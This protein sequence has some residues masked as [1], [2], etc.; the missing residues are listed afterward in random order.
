MLVLAKLITYS[1][2]FIILTRLG[3]ESEEKND[4]V[5][6]HCFFHCVKLYDIHFLGILFCEFEPQVN[7]I[8]I[9]EKTLATDMFAHSHSH[10]LFLETPKANGNMTVGYKLHVLV[11]DFL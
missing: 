11:E 4:I 3:I 2:V 5:T 9:G 7:S 6:H 10:S 1:E 8:K